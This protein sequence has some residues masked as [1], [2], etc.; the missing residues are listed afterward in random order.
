MRAPATNTLV[1]QII[2]QTFALICWIYNDDLE[3]LHYLNDVHLQGQY[4]S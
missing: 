4:L 1:Q 3:I 2:F